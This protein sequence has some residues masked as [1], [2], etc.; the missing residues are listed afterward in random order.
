MGE[1]GIRETS[2][3]AV[4]NSNYLIQNLIKVRG[5]TLPWAGSHPRRLQEARFSLQ[6]MKE[7]T[8]IGIDEVNRRIVDF[9]VQKCFPSHEPLIVKEPFTTEPPESTTKE[10][11]DRFVRVFQQISQEAYTNPEILKKAPH[12]CAISKIDSSP[13]NDPNKWA[14]TLKAYLKKQK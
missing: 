12:N 3:T 11:L 8:G 1:E 6:K 7:D 2:E 4:V 10:D 9:G 5:V 14:L 13:S